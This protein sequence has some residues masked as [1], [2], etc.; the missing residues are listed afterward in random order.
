MRVGSLGYISG[1]LSLEI[2]DFGLWI[3]R[4]WCKQDVGLVRS[5]KKLR[6]KVSLWSAKESRLVVISMEE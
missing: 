5:R 6:E 3:R 1:D 2:T 4:K